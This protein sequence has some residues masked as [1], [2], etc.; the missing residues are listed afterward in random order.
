MC[1]RDSC[2]CA[3][4]AVDVDP[5]SYLPI[6]VI[7]GVTH[8]AVKANDW[9]HRCKCPTSKGGKVDKGCGKCGYETS[10]ASCT[11]NTHSTHSIHSD[12]NHSDG[13]H[14]ECSSPVKGDCDK[15]DRYKRVYHKRE[16]HGG[17][18]YRKTE[19][20][21][22]EDEL[23]CEPKCAPLVKVCVPKP[24]LSCDPVPC[25]R[26]L[27]RDL[28][29]CVPYCLKDDEKLQYLIADVVRRCL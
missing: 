8:P 4:P 9:C 19:C 7:N 1:I 20:L 21:C 11:H 25:S 26:S 12:G 18:T 24:K 29:N 6:N 13:N 10:E 5:S 28:T 14:T 2:K 22:G 23:V 17:C 15:C 3:H 16:C 27:K